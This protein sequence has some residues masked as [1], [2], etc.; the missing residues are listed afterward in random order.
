MVRSPLSKQSRVVT[1]ALLA[2]L[3]LAGCPDPEA[4]FD[5]FVER[6]GI[7]AEPDMAAGGAGGGGGGGDVTGG[8][9][10]AGP[11]GC[12]GPHDVTG[13]YLFALSTFILP[14]RPLLFGAQVRFTPE[15]NG[16]SVSIT[17]QPLFCRGGAAEPDCRRDPAGPALP[18]VTFPVGRDGKFTADLGRV[19][20]TG[21]ANPISGADILAEL[22]L[23]GKVKDKELCGGISG[24]LI[25]PYE[26]PFTP[27]DSLFGTTYLGE[28]GAEVD[29]KTSEIRYLCSECP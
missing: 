18:E 13:Q 5:D 11:L 23:E 6:R 12:E 9:G 7:E 3:G 19:N 29:F 25:L 24:S 2:G 14:T 8:A 16:G 21:D 20:V 4:A 22:K 27:E 10:G 26:A 28:I 1:M 15:G 17:L